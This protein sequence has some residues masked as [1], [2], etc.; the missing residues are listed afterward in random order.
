LAFRKASIAVAAVWLAV[1]ASS[2]SA[3]AQ[4]GSGLAIDVVS[5]DSSR[6][7]SVST[8]VNVLDAKGRPVPGLTNNSFTAT[9]DGQPAAIEGLQS[10]VDSQV[11]LSVVLAVDASGSMAG[12]PLS[13]AQSA[14]AEFADGLS[15]QDLVAVLAF[16][17]GVTIVQ[18]PT[19]DKAA[20]IGALRNLDAAGDTALFE[21]TS[22]ATAEALESASPRR[23]I[24][25]LSDGVDYGGKS[26]VTRDDSIAT[27]RAAGVPVYTIALG[28]DVDK[29]Y[30][31]ELAQ[32]TGAR[33]LETPSPEGL[34]Q[35]Y[36][37]IGAV[38]RG[39]YVVTLQSPAV[40]AGAPHTLE[41]SVAVGGA[42]AVASRNLD[43]IPTGQSPEVVVDGLRP[44]D[45]LKS[46][47]TVT[48]RVSGGTP[49]EVRFLI[50]G[51]LVAT[52]GAAPY[53]A[54]LDPATLASGDHTLRVEARDASGLLASSEAGFAASPALGGG[55]SKMPLFVALTAVTLAAG[56]VYL[57][58][59]RRPRVRRQVVEVRLKPYSNNGAAA[60]S[61]SLLDEPLPPPVPEP[62]EEPGGKL[63]VVDG[64]DAGKEY[65]VGMN[66]VSIGTA[67]W[68]DIA[69]PDQDGSIGPEEAR[70]WV[71][72][73]KLI[74]HKLTRLTLLASDGAVG[75]WLI[76]E[77]GDEV[78]VGAFRLRFVS[79]APVVAE[80]DVLNKAV[81]EA[82]Q[83]FSS[84]PSDAGL[85][86]RL[87]WPVDAPHI[88][89]TPAEEESPQP[90]SSEPTPFDG[91]PAEA[92]ES[93]SVGSQA[94]SSR[95]WPTG[96]APLEP[97]PQ[98][99]AVSQ[100]VSS[101]P[102]P[103]GEP[104]VEAAES[105][106]V[107]SQMGSSRFWPTGSAPLEPL[108]QEEAGSQ[109]VPSEP[110]PSGEPPVEAVESEPAGIG[111]ER[112]GL[113][114]VDEPPAE[115]RG[116]EDVTDDREPVD[117]WPIDDLPADREPLD[118]DLDPPAAA[119]SA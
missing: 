34:S 108:P 72:Q 19:S 104:P 26:T 107:D 62:V 106:S 86:S 7:P 22:R 77:N 68:C 1:F 112:P 28:A 37:D 115:L 61:V 32:A 42:T 98:E 10:V 93:Q 3:V 16:S 118:E 57:L 38:L 64:P 60:G 102:G 94:G 114:P 111:T 73:D 30:L 109:P 20:V 31:S 46:A 116:P 88:R 117:L 44:G 99:E 8:V 9:V 90:V 12:A 101:E 71:H 17:D 54:T 91:P 14:A 67:G 75:G 89:S 119:S 63:I 50:D 78:N 92:P 103:S 41:L 24:I 100:P 45:S 56:G 81:N 87:L 51:T 96:S 58:Q 52:A 21:A 82:V 80:Q 29:A 95:F 47:V 23:V 25:L 39:Q 76:L 69:L 84:R 48:A 53:Q 4:D 49:T 36:A 40:D 97:F 13:A 59:R 110:G 66:P 55:S 2:L 27:A 15:P 79:L 6:F 5:V 11:S 113:W 83:H 33:F 105:Q 70:A 65:L 18:E 74:F 35:L 85:A 43:V